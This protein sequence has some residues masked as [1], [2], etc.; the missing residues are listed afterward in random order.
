MHDKIISFIV[1]IQIIYLHLVEPYI[2]FPYS[3]EF[4]REAVYIE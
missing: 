4:E 2:G 1:L 3:L